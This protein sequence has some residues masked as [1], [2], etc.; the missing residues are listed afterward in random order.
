MPL[1]CTAIT[2]RTFPTLLLIPLQDNLLQHQNP[3]VSQPKLTMRVSIVL[4]V[5]FAA[6]TSATSLP[7]VA[8]NDLEA[9]LFDAAKF[10]KRCIC[11]RNEPSELSTPGCGPLS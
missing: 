7:R 6:F 10:N 4:A 2:N 1:Y 11:V 8:T 5:A 3:K 9:R